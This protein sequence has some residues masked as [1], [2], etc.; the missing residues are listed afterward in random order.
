MPSRLVSK[1]RFFKVVVI[2]AIV[3]DLVVCEIVLIIV[4]RVVFF[5]FNLPK[6]ADRWASSQR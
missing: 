3:V 2:V 4:R 1:L 6:V 5:S